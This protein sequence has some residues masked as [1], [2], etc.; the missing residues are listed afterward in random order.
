MTTFDELVEAGAMALLVTI[1][2][3]DERSARL[4]LAF[5]E[6]RG[7]CTKEPFTCLRCYADEHRGAARAVLLAVMERLHLGLCTTSTTKR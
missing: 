1:G 5:T 3:L 6:H 2:D 7:D 4:H